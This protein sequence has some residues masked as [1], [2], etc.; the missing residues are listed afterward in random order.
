MY[1]ELQRKQQ[2]RMD[3]VDYIK[4]GLGGSKVRL[5]DFVEARSN[6]ISHFLQEQRKRESQ[7]L[8]ELSRVPS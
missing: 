3:A 5:G 7:K 6:R 4:A 8:E 1:Q 2:Q